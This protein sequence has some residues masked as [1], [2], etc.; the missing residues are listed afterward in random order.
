MK[1]GKGTHFQKKFDDLM[2]FSYNKIY[3]GNFQSQNVRSLPIVKQ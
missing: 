3:D 1:I 2:I